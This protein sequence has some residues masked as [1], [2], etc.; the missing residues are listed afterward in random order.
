[1]PRRLTLWTLLALS[2]M[3]T[4]SGETEAQEEVVGVVRLTSLEWPPY[5]GKSLPSQGAS[6][7]VVRAALAAM[8]QRL[9]VTFLPWTQAVAIGQN[10]KSGYQGYFPEYSSPNV[11]ATF[12]L[13]QPVGYGPLGLV[14][15]RSEPV[16]W[17]SLADL[18]GLRIG[19]VRGYVNT[20]EFDDM[21][22]SGELSAVFASD[23]LANISKVTR[24]R[25]P[26]AVIDKHVLAYL[27]ANARGVADSRRVLQFNERV[28]DNKSLHVALQ[29][30]KAGAATMQLINQ[31]LQ[32]IDAGAIA[33]PFFKSP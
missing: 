22:A 19:V 10:S 11:E 4:G 24:G 31:G 9:E 32:K 8:G 26:L 2:L 7:A 23:D 3:V 33:A 25:L 1:M 29:R 17:Q 5:A 12:E 18:K 14:E 13:S 27:M 15:R 20:V 30:N 21:V 16:R 6:V 28:L